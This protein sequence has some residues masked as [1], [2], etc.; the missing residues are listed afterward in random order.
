[1]K[2]FNPMK[3][4]NPLLIVGVAAVAAYL[5]FAGSGKQP[6]NLSSQ[7]AVPKDAAGIP[8]ALAA[9]FEYLSQNG[10]SSC[11]ASFR[12]S[13]ASG[14]T[15]SE[16]LQ[17]SCCSAMDPHRYAEQVDGLKKYADIPEIPPDPYDIDAKLAQ[18]LARSE[19][20]TS[21]L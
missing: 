2:Q 4:L 5:I 17:G 13:I 18:E 8:E 10:N 1:M 14:T 19:E 9:K 6:L 7:G 3:Q 21:E 15:G 11:S 12:Q 20:H 16:R